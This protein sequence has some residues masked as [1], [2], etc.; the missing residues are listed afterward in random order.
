MISFDEARILDEVF[1]TVLRQPLT[2]ACARCMCVA[3]ATA[4]AHAA[5][6]DI[7]L[8]HSWWDSTL[9]ITHISIVNNMATIN[10]NIKHIIRAATF[11]EHMC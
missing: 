3:H 2:G 7:T 4:A 9:I 8:T 11:E 10:T 6:H 5:E 1:A